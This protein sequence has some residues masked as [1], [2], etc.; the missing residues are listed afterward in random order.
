MKD[1]IQLKKNAMELWDILSTADRSL[2]ITEFNH[3]P[4]Y[5]DLTTL[6]QTKND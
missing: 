4:K 3:N 5:I 1:L 6:T 2:G